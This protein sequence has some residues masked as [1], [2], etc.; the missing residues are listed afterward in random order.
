MS[1]TLHILSKP[2][3]HQLFNTCIDT[4]DTKDSVI[5]IQDGCYALNSFAETLLNHGGAT[6]Q[7]RDIT[8]YA[9]REDIT[10]RGIN[11]KIHDIT[12]VNYVEFVE[13][14]VNHKRTVSW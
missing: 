5:L 6:G 12:I 7:H 2:P 10:A 4:L 13:L 9:L 14:T 3:G 1:Q 11:P 8:V